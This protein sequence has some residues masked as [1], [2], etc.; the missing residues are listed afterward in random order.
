[1]TVFTRTFTWATETP[2]N[3]G[4]TSTPTRRMPGC[5]NDRRGRTSS[6]IRARNGSWNSSWTTPET[7]TPSARASTGRVM[8]GASHRVAAMRHRFSSTGVNA[9]T[10]KRP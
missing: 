7:S 4:T 8:C 9:G 1:M 2:S 3:A 5:R 6:P 10:P